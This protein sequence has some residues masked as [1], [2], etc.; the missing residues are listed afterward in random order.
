MKSLTLAG[1]LFIEHLKTSS[2]QLGSRID[3]RL[4]HG[5]AL[6]EEAR[7]LFCD[8]ARIGQWFD[9]FMSRNQ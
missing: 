5:N 1:G 8:S 7:K 2:E 9:G 3:A 6:K 4:I